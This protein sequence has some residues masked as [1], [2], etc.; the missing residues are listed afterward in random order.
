MLKEARNDKNF[1]CWEKPIKINI[2]NINGGEWPGSIA[3][4]CELACNVGFLPNYSL[5]DIKE[6]IKKH[7]L[8]TNSTWI[9][10]HTYVNFNGLKNSAYINE[11]VSSIIKYIRKSK[12]KQSDVFGWIVSCDAHLYQIISKIP[13]YVWGCGDLSDAH[14]PHERLSLDELKKGILILAH[15]LSEY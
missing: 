7:C 15:Y 11:N 5:E 8:T 4:K 10:E 2:G 13:T 12:I 9:N 3:E 6:K 1:S 14:S